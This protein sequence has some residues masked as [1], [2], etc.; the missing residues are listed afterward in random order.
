MSSLSEL[1]SNRGA[2]FD[3]LL[4]RGLLHRIDD[5][6]TSVISL[7]SVVAHRCESDEAKA[8]LAAVQDR[9]QDYARIQQSLQMPEYSTTIDLVAYLQQLC[10]AVSRSKLAGN[11]IELLL[12]VYPLRMNSER[13][14]LLG[15]IVFELITHAA[16]HAFEG[17]G[18]IHIEIWPAGSSIECHVTY[19]GTPDRDSFQSLSIVEALTTG[20]QGEVD[21]QYGPNGTRTVVKLPLAE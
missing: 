15:M 1:S 2:I 16:R 17:A 11:G 8:G 18:S 19:N 6:L 20:L 10:R 9:L 21:F 12:S 7:I 14:W 13:C 4:L 3:R 5:E